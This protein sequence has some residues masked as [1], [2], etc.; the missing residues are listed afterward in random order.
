M[1]PIIEL[2]IRKLRS[3]IDFICWIYACIFWHEK[4]NRIPPITDGILLK[5][6]I[7]IAELIRARKVDY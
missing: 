6:A 4:K 3:S 2:L 1:N 7:E 5:P